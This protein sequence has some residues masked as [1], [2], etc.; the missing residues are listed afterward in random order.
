M[1]EMRMQRLPAVHRK[2]VV[3]LAR[4]QAGRDALDAD[5]CDTVPEHK[6]NRLPDGML[7]S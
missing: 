5:E 2:G 3:Q 7:I 1:Q 4:K 6:A